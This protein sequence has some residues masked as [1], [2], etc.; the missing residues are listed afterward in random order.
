V[1][2]SSLTAACFLFGSTPATLLEILLI[3]SWPLLG[4]W[5][6]VKGPEV[7]RDPKLCCSLQRFVTYRANLPLV[8]WL[9]AHWPC[10]LT[11]LWPCLKMGIDL[12]YDC[13]FV[14]LSLRVVLNFNEIM[15]LP[16]AEISLVLASVRLPSG[17]LAV[18][19]DKGMPPSLRVTHQ[20]LRKQWPALLP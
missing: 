7:R 14:F 3:F 8:R 1:E 15:G 4:Q 20:R 9:L 16:A 10:F 18:A 19:T 11:G 12:F 5:S 2:S 6:T 13:V 17:Q